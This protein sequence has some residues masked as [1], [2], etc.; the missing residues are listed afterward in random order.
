MDAEMCGLYD[1][2]IICFNFGSRRRRV[3]ALHSRF[4][5]S[6]VNLRS[7]LEKGASETGLNAPRPSDEWMDRPS[8]SR[9]TSMS[10]V[11]ALTDDRVDNLDDQK[12]C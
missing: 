1:L 9:A 4:G 12:I 3:L 7:R 10:S 6:I 5:N 8:A 2:M 11:P